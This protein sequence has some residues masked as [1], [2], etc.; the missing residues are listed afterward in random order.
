MNHHSIRCISGQN[1]L[2]VGN[3]RRYLASYHRKQC[4]FILAALE[5]GSQCEI[6]GFSH[7]TCCRSGPRQSTCQRSGG[8]GLSQRDVT[9]SQRFQMASPIARRYPKSAFNRTCDSIHL[10]QFWRQGIHGQNEAFL[11]SLKSTADNLIWTLSSTT[12][13]L[14]LYDVNIWHVKS[15]WHVPRW[16]V[17]CYNR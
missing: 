15:F 1:Q 4:L 13:L 9:A 17:L 12:F 8:M 11:S 5:E 7:P 10:R 2:S 14:D 16:S 3:W 6:A